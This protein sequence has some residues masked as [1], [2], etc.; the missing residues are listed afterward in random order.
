[1]PMWRWRRESKHQIVR[2]NTRCITIVWCS[3][4]RILHCGNKISP[5]L[6]VPIDVYLQSLNDSAVRT[7]IA[8]I[9]LRVSSECMDGVDPVRFD[10]LDDFAVN[11]FPKSV[12]KTVEL[13]KV[14]KHQRDWSMSFRLKRPAEGT[15]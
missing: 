14:Q 6:L 12:S 3:I 10:F 4:V 1:M 7:L 5:V 9:P 13:R 8:R 11:S 2:R 15:S